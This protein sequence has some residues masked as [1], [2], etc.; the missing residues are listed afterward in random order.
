[1]ASRR[2]RERRCAYWTGD[3]AGLADESE[4][5]LRNVHAKLGEGGA[6]RLHRDRHLDKNKKNKKVKDI[7]LNNMMIIA[8]AGL[9]RDARGGGGDKG[10]NHH[11]LCRK[12]AADG[13]RSLFAR[14]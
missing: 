13:S 3:S 4:S 14:T 1:M 12:R 8:C 6:G 9:P 5:V 11:T 10:E 7:Y 2:K